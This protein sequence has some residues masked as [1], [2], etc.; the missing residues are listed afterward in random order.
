MLIHHYTVPV[1]LAKSI[2]DAPEV[3]KLTF[4]DKEI[5]NIEYISFDKIPYNEGK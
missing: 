5:V 2:D 1:A 3:F 4:N